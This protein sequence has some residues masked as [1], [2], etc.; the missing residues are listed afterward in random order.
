MRLGKLWDEQTPSPP[1]ISLFKGSS[2]RRLLKPP[3]NVPKT[4]LLTQES[5]SL[6]TT[7]QVN[8]V[9]DKVGFEMGLEV[10][11]SHRLTAPTTKNFL[12]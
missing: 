3:K 9:C 12:I 11:V 8:A 10:R 1:P 4:E 5:V 2:G 7:Y 6:L